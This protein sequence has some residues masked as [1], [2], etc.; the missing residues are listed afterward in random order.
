MSQTIQWESPDGVVT[1]EMLAF[2][3]FSAE[4]VYRH[5][6]NGYGDV[7]ALTALSAEDFRRL[8]SFATC[9]G[10]TKAITFRL[11]EKPSKQLLSF[12]EWWKLNDQHRKRNYST[13]FDEFGDEVPPEVYR[14]WCSAYN[15]TR[16]DIPAAPPELAPG[17]LELAEKDESFLEPEAQS[18][19]A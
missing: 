14:W 7:E 10:H 19:I 3:T 11:P 18:S 12:V 15:E 6:L 13:I 2:E 1:F 17:T 9:L 5:V 16:E 8:S 4:T